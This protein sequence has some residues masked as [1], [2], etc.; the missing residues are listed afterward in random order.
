MCL[1]VMDYRRYINVISSELYYTDS[2]EM[3]FSE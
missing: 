3:P 1:Y 2:K